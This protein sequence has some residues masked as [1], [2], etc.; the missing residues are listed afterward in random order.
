MNGYD[1]KTKQKTPPS[2]LKKMCLRREREECEGGKD[3]ENGLE[4]EPSGFGGTRLKQQEVRSPYW[5]GK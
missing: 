2:L 5:E 3:S 4:Q 1:K